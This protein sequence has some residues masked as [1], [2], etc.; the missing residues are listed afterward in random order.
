MKQSLEI[1]DSRNENLSSAESRATEDF[2]IV[3]QWLGWGEPND[4]IWFIGVEEA[5]GWSF[6][7]PKKLAENREKLRTMK[8]MGHT[9]YRDKS[10]RVDM[11]FKVA[12]KTAKIAS[13]ANG[14]D[15]SE[16]RQYREEK[17]WLKGCKVFNGNLLSLGKRS[18]A[19]GLPQGFVELFGFGENDYGSYFEKVKHERFEAFKRFRNEHRPR[20][21]VCFGMSHW[22]QFKEL[23]AIIDEKAI[24]ETE[25]KTQVY[26]LNRVILT[27]HFSNGMPDQ[28]LEFIGRKIALWNI[29]SA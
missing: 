23:F 25:L 29:E 24:I 12:E 16:W 2:E 17:L 27:R 3:N 6:D 4:G 1:E 26:E 19:H 9:E 7:S 15:M 10:T 5:Y 22:I 28:T 8:G 18:L 14:N 21:I 20:A 11:D 13:I